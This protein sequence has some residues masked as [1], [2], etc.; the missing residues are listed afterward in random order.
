MNLFHKSRKLRYYSA[1][2]LT[3]LAPDRLFRYRLERILAGYRD[4][5]LDDVLDRVEY[6]NKCQ[7]P[8]TLDARAQRVADFR[9]ERRGT[10]YLD[11]KSVVRHFDPE[12]RF[13]YRFGDVTRVP[14]VPAFVKSRPIDGDN[15]NAVLLKLNQIRHYNFVDDPQPFERKRTA[16]VWRGKCFHDQRRAVIQRLH[17][18]PGMDIGQ[19]DPKRKAQADYRPFMAIR[20][21][22]NYKFVLSLEG[23][24]VATNLKWI[25]AS[26]SLCFMPR[27]RFET[28]FMEGRLEPWRHYV[29]LR[30]DCA[31]IE[32]KMD[33]YATHTDEAL[34][35]IANAQQHVAQF[36]D[37]QRER[38]VSLLVARKYFELSGQ[39]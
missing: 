35:I 31:D 19:T 22:L 24:D 39:L 16:V 37:R 15:A 4:Q 8:F 17:D 34:E 1:G 5:A 14:E 30:D 11:T 36:K 27:P 32:E 12:C 28:W 18:T 9:Y 6:Y 38:L 2:L 25:M 13:A 21:Q 3:L 20:D 7:L 29:P 23:K 10:Y 33:Y 26:N